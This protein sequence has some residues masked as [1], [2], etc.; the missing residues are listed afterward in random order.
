MK[1]IK[2]TTR[3]LR[4]SLGALLL[5]LAAFFT[6]DASA[7]HFRYGSIKWRKINNTS[8]VV[9]FTISTAWRT[10]FFFPSNSVALGTTVNSGYVFNFGEGVTVALVLK[11]TSVDVANGW[12]FAESILT[13]DYVN[14]GN[15]IAFFEN[16]CRLSNL[17]NGADGNFR[18]QTTVN[19]GTSNNSPSTTLPPIINLQEEQ[20]A[21]T[22]TIPVA[23]PDT[24]DDVTFSLASIG[25]VGINPL[26]GFSVN[27]TTG[28]ASFNTVGKVP[29][30]LWTAQVK[31]TDGNAIVFV[32]FIIQIVKI[33]NPPH[34]VYTT[35][36]ANGHVFKV[37][38][39]TNVAFTVK[40]SDVDSPSTVALSG[41]GIPSGATFSPGAPA[42]PISTAF[43]WTPTVSQLGVFV[44]TFT[45]T[46]N[47]G[48]QALTSVTIQVSN[49]PVFDIPPTP[50]DFEYI[51]VAPGETVEFDVQASDPDP[52]DNVKINSMMGKDN[53]GV[54]VVITDPLYTGVSLSPF[55]TVNANPT[56][57]EFSWTVS[58]S[59]W[60]ERPITFTAVDGF[61]DKADHTVHILVNTT[62]EFSSTPVEDVCVGSLY[63]YDVAGDDP[64][65][66]YGDELELHATGLPSWATFVDNGD[67][68]GTLSGT[69]APGDEG[70]YDVV[71]HL[72]DIYHHQNVPE[73]PHQ[74]FTIHVHGLPA[75]EAGADDE[76]CEG[77]SASI[78]ATAVAGS[79]YSWS[80]LPAGY[81]SSD[82]MN[83]VSP[84]STTTYSVTE[85]SEHGCVNSNDVT[86]TVNPLPAADA[87]PDA[88]VCSGKSATI[89]AGPV[90]GSTYSW[91]SDPSGFSSSNSMA[92]VSP[93]STTTYTLVETSGLGCVN[94][95][96][97]VITVYAQPSANAGSD[98]TVYYGYSP[99]SCT[100]LSGSASGGTTPYSYSWSNGPTTTGNTVCPTSTT[101]YT[102]EVKDANNCVATDDATVNVEDVHCG[103]NNNKVSVCHNGN[104]LCISASAVP[105]HLAHSGD[106]LGNCTGPAGGSVH[107][108]HGMELTGSPNPF[109]GTAL[110]H[111]EASTNAHALVQVYSIDGKLLQTLFDGNVKAGEINDLVVGDKLPV[112][113]VFIVK[114]I[115][116]DESR[117]IR[118]VKN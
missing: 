3:F 15:K 46:D 72:E 2:L 84:G 105:A 52:A 55:P 37:S 43:S 114:A 48:A 9:E 1:Q 102:L 20:S 83:S 42:R 21:A 69:P 33:S 16:C 27:S 80:S 28:E 12:F 8:D 67:G 7:T 6:T 95:N 58:G 63:S 118:I 117:V 41:T 96:D 31:M 45:A 38:S 50:N 78:G 71:I 94:S 110:I 107:H 116:G 92:T 73:I 88:S 10:Q 108:E 54:A 5:L 99:L 101:T 103:N 60:G 90:S 49:A 14:P 86:V 32:D 104:S 19:V 51:V 66:A 93:T 81:S 44:I 4:G 59:Q 74:E 112:S 22:F 97:V 25:E 61:G 106:Y 109:N 57:G 82:A 89:G 91:S 75:A 111:F 53:N 30:Q 98:A 113:G 34:F 76:I 65:V 64:D 85:T 13:K 87:G 39:G 36:P 11:V 35:T 18:V 62:P 24:G 115:A 79:T 56:S 40:A 70:D 23:D 68:T 47:D 17:Q 26:S 29:G 77:E 100:T